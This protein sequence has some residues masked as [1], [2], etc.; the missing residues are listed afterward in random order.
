MPHATLSYT[1]PD[2]QAEYDAARLGSEALATLWE[3][4]QRCR[5]LLKHGSPTAEQRELAEEIRRL[6]PAELLEH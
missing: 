4:D 5:G 1:L 2:E 3:I 6:I